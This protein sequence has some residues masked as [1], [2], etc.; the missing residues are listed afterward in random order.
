[1]STGRI[2]HGDPDAVYAGHCARSKIILH[3]LYD[4]VTSLDGTACFYLDC[5]YCIYIVYYG[6]RC[7]M[8]NFKFTLRPKLEKV[9]KE[10]R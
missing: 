6:R 1:M 8:R 2:C 10:G 4:E 5:I 3:K 7:I 9:V